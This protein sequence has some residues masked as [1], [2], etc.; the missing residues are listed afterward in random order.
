MVSYCLNG[1]D[2]IVKLFKVYRETMETSSRLTNSAGRKSCYISQL[3][4]APAT[5]IRW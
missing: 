3:I 1:N 4:K 5:R 2:R